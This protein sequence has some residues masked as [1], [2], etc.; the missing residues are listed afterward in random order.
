[1]KVV[2]GFLFMMAALVGLLLVGAFMINSA[3]AQPRT[4]PLVS[5]TSSCTAPCSIG[6]GLTVTILPP[7]S[8]PPPSTPPPSTPPPTAEPTDD[9]GPGGGKGGT[10]A[11]GPDNLPRT[12]PK[13]TAIAAVVG[14]LFLQAGLMMSVRTA[15]AVPRQVH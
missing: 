8:T 10:G 11:A 4:A 12:G 1:V 14:L 9:G 6:Q 5:D 2:Q 3:A 15:R 7:G 13:E